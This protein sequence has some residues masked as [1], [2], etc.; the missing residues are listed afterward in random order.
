MNG[1]I[2][3]DIKKGLWSSE[4]TETTNMNAIYEVLKSINESQIALE[5]LEVLS[6]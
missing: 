2:V 4:V 3:K 1:I 6:I 5:H